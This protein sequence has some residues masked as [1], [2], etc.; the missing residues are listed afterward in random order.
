MSQEKAFPCGAWFVALL[1]CVILAGSAGIRIAAA[2]GAL[3]HDP[4]GAP[5]GFEPRAA[6]R[7][8]ATIPAGFDDQLRPV[9]DRVEGAPRA[10]ALDLLTPLASSAA[11]SPLWHWL[12]SIE[13]ARRALAT[14][15]LE[16][17]RAPALSERRAASEVE[18]AWNRG[19][20]GKAIEALRTFEEAGG[21]CAIAVSWA[22]GADAS[23]LSGGT[24]VRLGGLRTEGHQASLDYD[25][26]TGHLCCVVR[27]GT[28]TGTS[29]WTVNFSS[30]DGATWSE[31]ASYISSLGL[32]DVS[33]AAVSGLCYVG[34]VYGGDAGNLRVRRYRM[35]DGAG[36]A[37][38]GFQSIL[39]AGAATIRDVA[40]VTNSEDYDNR[41]YV[42]TI[43]SDH[44]L[45]YAWDVSTD[46]TTFTTEASPAVADADSALDAS[47]GN[48]RGCGPFLFVSY[49]GTDGR[50]HVQSRDASVWTDASI[51]SSA[52]VSRP[53][54]VSVYQATVICA[55]EHLYA[56]GRGIQYSI[57]YDCGATWNVGLLADPGQ[58][59]AASFMAPDVDAR[60][61]H[62]T[63]I[64]Y[65]A[66]AG[67]P[68]SAYYHVRQG[69]QP[70]GWAAPMVFNDHDVLTGTQ[71][72]IAHL[73]R[74][75]PHALSHG[76]V[77]YGGSSVPYFDYPGA[78]V[79]GAPVR[80]A[81][82]V[83]LRRVGEH[84]SRGEAH[85]EFVLPAATRGEVRVLDVRGAAV[86]E[87]E[88]GVL[89]AGAHRVTWDGA[90]S[91][92]TAAASGVYFVVLRSNA[93][94]ARATVVLMR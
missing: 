64:T 92:G 75:S 54:S 40:V 45:R 65:T 33:A 24:D 62:G 3:D 8:G 6:A 13:P 79:V 72:A 91:D 56:E 93:G 53:T 23:P 27:W 78:G 47:W 84:P 70:G 36:D 66:E 39:D 76:A 37:A 63:A 10:D 1:A 86:R 57:S 67:E 32:I 22:P 28:T 46:G 30:N 7:A 29:A 85:F 25:I 81:A 48:A 5:P 21:R 83:S 41:V 94:L 26:A 58:E 35:S 12:S 55:Y 51:A 88:R 71:T 20:H 17:G 18:A 77:Y 43:Q 31:T 42:F 61:G 82:A 15:Q 73:P 87:L 38:Y 68:D 2:D 59:F 11:A 80:A 50:I 14:V 60:D 9:R 89:P 44:A 19:D 34:Y 52:G 90:R 16:F 49:A 74:L 4:S 69:Y